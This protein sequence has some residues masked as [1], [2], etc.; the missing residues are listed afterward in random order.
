MICVVCGETADRYLDSQPVCKHC[1][2]LADQDIEAQEKVRTRLDT[3]IA[4]QMLARRYPS[5]ARKLSGRGQGLPHSGRVLGL[6]GDCSSCG[7]K[8]GE[9]CSW[10]TKL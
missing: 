9:R 7:A 10:E 6:A 1:R 5:I 8:P 4:R 2:V 3:L